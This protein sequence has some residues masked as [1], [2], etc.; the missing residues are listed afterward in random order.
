MHSPDYKNSDVSTVICQEYFLTANK[1]IL[2]D[3]ANGCGPKNSLLALGYAGWG[4]GQLEEE[5]L[6]DSW[7]LC[8]SDPHLVFLLEPELKWKDGL[9]KLGVK[10]SHL[11]TFGGSA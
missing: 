1:E 2:R 5:I 10:P 7:L 8:D 11:A 3:I 6:S 4:P 9:S